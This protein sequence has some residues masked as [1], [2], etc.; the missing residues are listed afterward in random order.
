[1]L[2]HLPMAPGA[3]IPFDQWVGLMELGEC[4]RKEAFRQRPKY[5]DSKPP[6]LPLL[7]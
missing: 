4:G 1:M 5:A 2:H 3:H 7:G 6:A